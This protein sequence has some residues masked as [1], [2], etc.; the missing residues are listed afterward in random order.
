MNVI[1]L[2]ELLSGSEAHNVGLVSHLAEPGKAG[3][4]ALDLAAKLA[5]RSPTA[6]QLAK[7]AIST[8]KW[9]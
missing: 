1:L 2:G 5:S 4:R 3:E 6:I 7:E 9:N 8:G